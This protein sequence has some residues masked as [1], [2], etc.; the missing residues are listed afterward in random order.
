VSYDTFIDNKLATSQALPAQSIYQQQYPSPTHSED[1][2][3]YLQQS[4]I[5][6]RDDHFPQ[7][8]GQRPVIQRYNSHPQLPSHH[9][10]LSTVGVSQADYAFPSVSLAGFAHSSYQP[11][12]IPSQDMIADVKYLSQPVLGMSHV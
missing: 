3:P 5:S 4:D 1:H 12:Q 6:P 2:N 9:S 8:A 10:Q 7:F 11:V